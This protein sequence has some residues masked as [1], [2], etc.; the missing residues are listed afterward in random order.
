[1]TDRHRREAEELAHLTGWD[2]A[3]I[4][5]KMGPD[6]QQRQEDPW[7]KKLWH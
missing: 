5:R 6:G 7:Y 4:T 3:S 1:L 2:L